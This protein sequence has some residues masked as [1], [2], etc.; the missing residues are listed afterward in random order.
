V[1]QEYKRHIC[2]KWHRNAGKFIYVDMQAAP[3]F[4]SST[5]ANGI[6]REHSTDAVVRMARDLH[7]E[8]KNCKEFVSNT[9]TCS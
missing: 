9:S 1:R 8:V 7:N 5:V 3:L 6:A 2:S 4:M